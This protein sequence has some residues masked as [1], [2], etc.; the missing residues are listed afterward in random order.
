MSTIAKPDPKQPAPAAP[1]GV[2]PQSGI[3]HEP[4]PKHLVLFKRASSKNAEKLASLLKATDAGRAGAQGTIRAMRLPDNRRVHVHERTGVATATLTND[5][6]A[7]LRQQGDVEVVENER[8]G[9]PR[10]IPSPKRMPTP[11]RDAPTERLVAYLQGVIDA[12][13]SVLRF[14]GRSPA[15]PGAGALPSVMPPA[16]ARALDVSGDATWA[17]S[18]IGVPSTSFTG[19]GAVVA[20]LDTGVDLTH[21]DLVKHF[22]TTSGTASF[23]DGVASV[24][25]GNGHGTHCA[26]VIAG[27]ASPRSGPRYSVAPDVTLLIGKVLDDEGGGFDDG[28]VQGIEWAAQMGAQIVSMSLGSTRSAG[29]PFSPLYERVGSTLLDQDIL[30]V[31]AAG[32]E[33]HRP[34][35]IAPLGNPAACPSFAAVA[36]IDSSNAVAWF[37]CGVV[38]NVGAIALAA[39][40]V[41]I[42][43]AWTGGDYKL[44]SGTSMA[45]P[46]VAGAAA[47]WIEKTGL[48]GRALL[49]QLAQAARAIDLAAADVGA[50]LVQAP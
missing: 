34:S 17:L 30:L 8:R 22:P 44:E 19:K 12:S 4:R 23:V 31:A 45:T 36:A 35:E 50:G 37:S 48:K 42:H 26:G 5:E 39:P 13:T 40:G 11:A 18:A 33:S 28:I 10:P 49:K 24:Q 20:V 27:A 25:D 41:G 9:L 29:T 1:L 2:T 43:S 3:T 32:N 46:H 14:L 16:A 21:P 15:V 47:L 38:D 7:N 6:I